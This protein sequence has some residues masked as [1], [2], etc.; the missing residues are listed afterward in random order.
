MFIIIPGQLISFITFPGVI[1]HEISHRFFCDI[2]DVPVYSVSYFI[3]FSEVAGCVM[4]E[5]TASMKKSLLISMGPLIINSLVCILL[6]FPYGTKLV[7]GTDFVPHDSE[8]IEYI[9][10]FVI[11]LGFSAGFQAIPSNRDID[12]VLEV[13]T[14][15]TFSSSMIVAFALFFKIFTIPF[16]GFV[17]Q[18]SFA[19]MLIY[20]LPFFIF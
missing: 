18:L 10:Y 7:L 14:G 17:F 5:P 4:H 15:K 8:W 2:N 9:N 11:W 12:N 20:L 3:P 6:T 19:W 16:I 1:L 13:A